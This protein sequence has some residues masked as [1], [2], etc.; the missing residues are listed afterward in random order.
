MI[1][2]QEKAANLY[3]REKILKKKNRFQTKRKV[4]GSHQLN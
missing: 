2:H 4:T 3:Q 1:N